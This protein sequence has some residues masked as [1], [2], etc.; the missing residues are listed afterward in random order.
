MVMVLRARLRH[1]LQRPGYL[2]ILLAVATLLLCPLRPAVRV[3]VD[4]EELGTY[5]PRAVRSC[6]AAAEAAAEEISGEAVDLREAVRLRC[7]LS[8]KARSRD[9]KQLE[10]RLLDAAPG[11]ERLWVVYAGDTALGAIDDPTVLGELQQVL[12]RSHAGPYTVA[13]RLEPELTLRRSF[14]RS[15]ALLSHEELGERLRQTVQVRTV[16]MAQEKLPAAE[17]G[18]IRAQNAENP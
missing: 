4:G 8:F 17:Y 2:L 11:V 9:L 12:V 13:A 16:D 3:S 1:I 10:R 7:V 5:A 18:I 14:V 15:D 6:V